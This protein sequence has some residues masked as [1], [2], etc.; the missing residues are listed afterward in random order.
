MAT[1]EEKAEFSAACSALK[2]RKV[3]KNEFLRRT[4][5]YWQH[6][7]AY[8]FAHWQ[9]RLPAW[10]EAADVEQEIMQLGLK[11]VSKWTAARGSEIGRY[12]TWNAIHRAQRQLDAWRGASTH[13]SSGKNPSRSEIAFTRA[14]GP[15]VDPFARLGAEPAGQDDALARRAVLEDALLACETGAE[16]VALQA[17]WAAGGSIQEAAELIAGNAHARA[18]CRVAG[19]AEARQLVLGVVSR[20]ASDA[21]DAVEQKVPT[22]PD[23]LFEFGDDERESGVFEIEDDEN[24]DAR[25]RA[26]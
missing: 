1:I 9:R 12:V 15:D 25:T 22:P 3:G 7:A 16:A 24:E 8:L 17:L 11:F 26:A 6:V 10:V 21:P 5:R 18:E 2:N 23:E 4:R 14:F 13:G 20:L 19:P